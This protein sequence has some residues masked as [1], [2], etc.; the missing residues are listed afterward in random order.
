MELAT[1]RLSLVAKLNSI[2]VV[3]SLAA[4]FSWA[5]DQLD[6]KTVFLHGDLQEVYMHLLPGL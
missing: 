5:L 6:V 2:R 4:D 3:L 1:L